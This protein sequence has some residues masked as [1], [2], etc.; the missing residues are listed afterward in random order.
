LA[1]QVR[2][3][4]LRYFD[5]QGQVWTDEWLANKMPKSLL[6]EITFQPSGAEPWTVREWVTI[7]AS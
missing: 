6:I 3:F 4:N 2:A 5:G 1:N 7:E